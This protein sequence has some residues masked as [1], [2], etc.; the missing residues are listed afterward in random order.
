M[1]EVSPLPVQQDVTHVPS[2]LWMI[3][4]RREEDA[5]LLMFFSWN[6][7]SEIYVH[8]KFNTFDYT[9][10]MRTSLSVVCSLWVRSSH[11]HQTGMCADGV[12]IGVGV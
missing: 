11:L 12:G 2:C 4:V 8:S 7:I 1:L 5:T 3:I 9:K 6:L 10:Y